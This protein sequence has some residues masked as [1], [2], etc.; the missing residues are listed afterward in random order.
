M[1]M[2]AESTI[3]PDIPLFD[4]NHRPAHDAVYSAGA[5]F[6]V[7][8]PAD[9]TSFDVVRF[10]RNRIRTRKTGHAGTL[11]PL[12]TGLLILCAGKATKLVSTFQDHTKRYRAV[13]TL[14]ASTPSYDAGTPPD[15]QADWA[16]VTTNDIRQVLSDQFTGSLQQV[17]PMYSALWKDGERL[18]KLARKGETV[19]REP[20][21]ITIHQI[22]LESFEEDRITLDILCSKGTYI[23]TLAHDLGLATG[24]RAYLSELRRTEIGPYCVSNAMTIDQ[25]RAIRP[26]HE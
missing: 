21:N 20:R 13:L 8:K 2:S 15:A 22:S 24:T 10:L 23:R 25:V 14:G 7:D 4:R 16:H 5:I 26:Y 19:D 3:H 1:A 18:Y 6:L 17:P 12:A 11:D 9:W